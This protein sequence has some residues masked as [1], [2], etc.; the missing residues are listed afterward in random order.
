[1]SNQIVDLENHGTPN[2]MR[3]VMLP[4]SVCLAI[5][6]TFLSYVEGIW[7]MCLCWDAWMF[8]SDLRTFM[9]HTCFPRNSNFYDFQMGT[10]YR[11]LNTVCTRTPSF[12]IE[13][14]ILTHLKR[15]LLIGTIATWNYC[16]F[17]EQYSLCIEQSPSCKIFHFNV[18]LQLNHFELLPGS[19]SWHIGLR[20]LPG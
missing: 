11:Q 7:K 13:C 8:Y 5:F 12:T 15:W 17:V 4:T 3:C 6:L 2:K 1:M 16:V 9:S 14:V 20:E 10:F 18:H 19:L